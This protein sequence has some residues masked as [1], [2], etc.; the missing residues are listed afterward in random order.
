MKKILPIIILALIVSSCSSVKKTQEALN[1]G[2]YD[3]A[4][5]KAIQKL[6]NDKEK[7]RNQP[8]IVMLEDAFEKATSRDLK[9]ISFLK[10]DGNPANFESIFE[11]YSN[12]IMIQEQIRPLLPLYNQEKGGYANFKLNDYSNDII[13]AKNKLSDYLY[14]NASNLLTNSSSKF[15]YRKAYSDLK[16]LDQINPNYKD[17]LQKLEEAHFKGTDFVRVS[18]YN[19]TKMVIPQRLEDELLNFN[20][21]G[22]NDIWTVYHNNS[23]KEVKYD[24]EMDVSFKDISI[25]PEQVH[26]KEVI[27]EKE[28]V[29]GWE[30][31]KDKRGNVAKDSLGNDIKVDIIKN[32]RCVFYEFSQFKAVKVSGSVVFK[33]LNTK[34]IVN[35][36]PLISEF[37]FEHLYADYDGDKRALD[38]PFIK[39]LK[40]KS[41]PFPS[42][43]Q[44]VYDAGEDLKN[45]LKNIII[46]HK[47]N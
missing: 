2:D 10:K 24:Y 31:V 12:L 13:D 39:L 7:K 32:V 22:L 36:Y 43:E 5:N 21:Y 3:A 19:D 18:M 9:Q 4:I 45:R 34:Q 46:K 20:T 27:K 17:V 26:E 11:L 8:Y 29:D 30:Y 6:R 35:S 38:R 25:S 42:N 28:I 23:V 40:A 47:F 37:I 14:T 15:D 41:V 44:M 16:Y 1:M 33:N